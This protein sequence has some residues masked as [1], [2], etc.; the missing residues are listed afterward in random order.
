MKAPKVIGLVVLSFFLFMSLSAFGLAFTINSTLLNKN[1][2]PNEV[3]RLDI[4][5]LE[6]DAVE[7]SGTDLSPDIRDAV[8]RTATALEPQVKAQFRAA[9]YKIYAYL[10]GRTKTLDLGQILKETILNKEFVASVENEAG[11]VALARQSLRDELADLIPS[12]LRQ[13]TVYLD[14][15]MPSLDPW[16]RQQIDAA[17]EPVID[18]L[19]GDSPTLDLTISLSEMKPVLRGAVRTAFLRSPP[20][21]LAGVSQA[22]L[23][24]FF[25]QYYGEFER[26]TPNTATVDPATLGLSSSTSLAQGLSDGEAGLERARTAIGQFRLYY[27]LSIVVMVILALGIA[28]LHH[29]VKGATRDLGIVLLSYGFLEFMGI[30]VAGYIIAGI[31]V[32]GLPPAVQ[33]WLPGLYWDVF[34]PLQILC[35][36]LAIL[37]LGMVL[38]SVLYRRRA[39]A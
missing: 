16:L 8:V 22:E 30:L 34:R 27:I 36:V 12:G 31:S 3:D 37:G 24:I 17:S 39:A 15:A 1:F 18:F 2:L 32:A 28:F 6:A 38:V 13:L 21:E 26:Q 7:A 23:D 25:N 29:E 11:V 33:S 4:G 20:A 9:N 19:V 35:A 5:P 14:Q 10:L